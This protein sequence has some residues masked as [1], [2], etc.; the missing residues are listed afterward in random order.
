MEVDGTAGD[1]AWKYRVKAPMAVEEVLLDAVE[2]CFFSFGFSGRCEL[3]QGKNSPLRTYR[4]L[5]PDHR[6][7]FQSLPFSILSILPV[8]SFSVISRSAT[9]EIGQQVRSERH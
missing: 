7:E 3:D 4:T 5:C 9:P 8:F 6:L 1:A 2:T